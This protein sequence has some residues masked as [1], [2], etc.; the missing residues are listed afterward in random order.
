MLGGCSR[1]TAIESRNLRRARPTK[2]GRGSAEPG[3]GQCQACHQ[4]KLS[5]RSSNSQHL[6]LCG[7]A[8]GEIER[9]PWGRID[10][11]DLRLSRWIAIFYRG[12]PHYSC[13]A[14]CSQPVLFQRL[15]KPPSDC[16]V[17][18]LPCYL[19]IRPE[20]SPCTT[21]QYA[22]TAMIS[23]CAPRIHHAKTRRMQ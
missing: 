7:H 19:N 14:T 12:G 15:L 22:N 8:L 11:G 18:H 4:R 1:E 16:D 23:C 2:I 17:S 6:A 13:H 3:P 9:E 10:L 21:Y 5:G 20:P